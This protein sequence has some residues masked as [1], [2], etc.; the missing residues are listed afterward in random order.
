MLKEG[1][2]YFV[3]GV[4]Q[5]RYRIQ[6]LNY[7]T[8]AY[9]YGLAKTP[10]AFTCLHCLQDGVNVNQQLIRYISWPWVCSDCCTSQL[11][12]RLLSLPLPLPPHC[13]ALWLTPTPPQLNSKSE[14][15]S[16]LHMVYFVLPCRDYRYLAI[17]SSAKYAFDCFVVKE[18]RQL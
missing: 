6:N 12:D 16:R 17:L 4:K 13:H 14:L 5:C 1:W 15:G 8:R 10:I 18:R 2:C 11:I 3:K 7:S 9:F